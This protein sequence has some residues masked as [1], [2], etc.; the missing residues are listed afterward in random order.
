MR[1]IMIRMLLMNFIVLGALFLVMVKLPGEAEAATS[2]AT[3]NLDDAEQTANVGPG[4]SG[5]VKFS[6]SV[7]AQLV[8]PGQS[9][10]MIVVNLASQCTW[11]STISPSTLHFPAGSSEAKPFEVVVRVP[12]FTP[13]SQPGEVFVTGQSYT[14]PGTPLYHDVQ[15]TTGII[16]ILP[17]YQ[18]GISCEKP[19]IEISPGDPLV[20]SLKVQNQ[21]NSLD[22]ITIDVT[23]MGDLAKEEWVVTLGRTTMSLDVNKEEVV[24]ISIG[25]PEDWTLYRNRVTKVD[26]TVASATSLESGANPESQKYALFIR[27]KGIYIPGFEPIFALLAL[28]IVAVAMRVS[29]RKRK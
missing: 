11:P 9:V 28:A 10:Q 12:N 21:G 2:V 18:L 20:F 14:V 24:K 17:Y 27:D 29:T 3:I 19:Y 25:S 7:T 5:I 26:V 15:G 23:N 13:F 22:E 6:G 1:K 4:Q 16:S 8:G